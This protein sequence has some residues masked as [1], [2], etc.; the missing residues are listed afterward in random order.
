MNIDKIIF[1]YPSKITG[2]AEYLFLRCAEYLAEHHNKYAISIVDYEDGFLRK[3]ASSKKITFI[4]FQTGIKTQIPDGSAVIVQLNILPLRDELFVYD[5]NKSFFMFWCLH[6]HNIKNYIGRGNRFV[7]LKRERKNLGEHIR[8]L[9]E[10]NVIKFMGFGAYAI[11]MRDLFQEPRNCEWLQNIIPI[12][13]TDHEP[14]YQIVSS[15]E[16]KFCWLGRLDAE[17][18]RNIETYMNELESLNSKMKLSLSII[19]LG[20]KEDNLREIACHYSYPIHFVGEKRD[21]DLD[22]FIRNETEI[23]LASGTSALEFS[24]RGKPV[25]YEGVIDRVYEAGE[26]KRYYLVSEG[27][28][29]VNPL[30]NELYREKESS[31]TEKVSQIMNDYQLCS[32]IE[33]NYVLQFAPSNCANKLVSIIGALAQSDQLLIKQRLDSADRLLKRGIRRINCIKKLVSI[34]KYN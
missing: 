6:T 16:L 17:K 23:G 12:D 25:V 20:P 11:V 18:A 19:G 26:R 10:Q 9:T 13:P 5:S 27:Q 3:N 2:G 4:E 31:F 32:K 33:Y 1:Y 15:D 28:S 34:C 22:Q 14:Q 29:K 8:I 21:E 7:M 24:K 30:T